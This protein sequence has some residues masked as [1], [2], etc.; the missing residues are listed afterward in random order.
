MAIMGMGTTITR[1]DC[2]YLPIGIK[3]PRAH[4]VYMD[5]YRHLAD[6]VLY[7]HAGYVVF[8]V[9]GLPVI[10]IGAA[11]R[12]GWVR[13]FWFRIVHLSLMAVVGL[14]AVIDMTCPLTVLE[15][16]FRTLA[17]QQMY[18]REFLSYWADRLLYL[19]WPAWAFNALHICFTI[20]LIATFVL[21]PPRWPWKS[22]TPQVAEPNAA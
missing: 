11:C 10:L 13:N 8:V 2:T 20:V 1:I 17:G 12:W 5:T 18:E 7:L 4:H 15:R 6:A 19:D 21:I 9:L 22:P 14:E 16:H 3:P